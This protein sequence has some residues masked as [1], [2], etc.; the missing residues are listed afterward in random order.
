MDDR[1]VQSF[2]DGG[3]SRPARP[4]PPVVSA[5]TR[6]G[7]VV[8]TWSNPPESNNF[9]DRYDEP[10]AYIFAEDPSDLNRTYAFAGYRVLQFASADDSV[11][12]VIGAASLTPGADR[13]VDER[14]D[15]RTGLWVP[16]VFVDNASG[17]IHFHVVDGLVNFREYHFGVQAFALNVHARPRVLSSRIARVTAIPAPVDNRAG[18]TV[19]A[20]SVDTGTVIPSVQVSGSEDGHGPSAWIFDPAGISG[21]MYE[22]SFF[23]ASGE[24]VYDLRDETSDEA[25]VSGRELLAAYGFSPRFG[26]GVVVRDGLSFNVDRLGIQPGDVFRIDTAP[27]APSRGTFAAADDSTRQ[28]HLDL[29]GAVPNPYRGASAYERSPVDEVVR[30]VNLPDE[31]VVRIYTLSGT[32]VR[33]LTNHGG[34][35][36]LDWDLRNEH[37]MRV[38]SGMYLVHIAMPELGEKVIKLGVVRGRL[39]VE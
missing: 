16:D 34:S 30:F 36:T 26:I 29:V 17:Q 9:F 27:Y 39:R 10:G 8:L 11:G 2:F 22:F 18:G 12:T 28:A 15:V 3:F 25:I 5:S 33:T 6:D 14:L 13:I 23:E 1:L 24:L 20:P 7:T 19:P 4:D 32:H 31:A 21:H 35:T 37:S 38:G